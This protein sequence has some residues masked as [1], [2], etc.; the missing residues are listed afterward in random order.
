ML[1]TIPDREPIHNREHNGNMGK[2]GSGL[3][4]V[5]IPL[6]DPISN[7]S[8]MKLQKTERAM[9]TNQTVVS[10]FGQLGKSIA[11]AGA[12]AGLTLAAPAP[13]HAGNG[14]AIGLGILGGV[15][16]GAA[17]A[18]TAPPVYG[19]APPAS[20][21]YYP[22]PYQSYYGPSPTDYYPGSQPYY[23]GWNPYR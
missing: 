2:L 13:A 23:Y 20:G 17:I 11:L 9:R 19:Y 8:N 22:Q 15:I 21:Y 7:R 14:A 18:S 12:I 5:V 16:A 10:R 6:R 3:S 1:S 4:G